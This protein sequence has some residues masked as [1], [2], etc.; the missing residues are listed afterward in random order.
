L[1]R[2]SFLERGNGHQQANRRKALDFV[3]ENVDGVTRVDERTVLFPPYGVCHFSA[4]TDPNGA[5]V[6]TPHRGDE[7]FGSADWHA[8]D[9]IM[10]FRDFSDGRCMIYVCPIPPLFDNQKIGHHGV[11]W[12]D[13]LKLA[14][15]KQVF[16]IE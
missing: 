15:F 16:R 14:S 6:S 12:E 13:V 4:Y 2:K 8:R 9:H 3:L 5:M 11:R 10:M 7:K 1:R